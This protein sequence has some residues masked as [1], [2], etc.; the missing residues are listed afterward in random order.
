MDSLDEF[1]D[2]TQQTLLND[3]TLDHICAQLK[4]VV[5][6]TIMKNKIAKSTNFAKPVSAANFCSENY[7]TESLSLVR[8]LLC[9]LKL[10]RTLAVFESEMELVSFQLIM[11]CYSSNPYI[12][13]GVH[14]TR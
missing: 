9:S 14:V 8:D 4:A 12:I 6:D 10:Q 2:L 1:I 3:G 11:H 7:G 5:V 13:G